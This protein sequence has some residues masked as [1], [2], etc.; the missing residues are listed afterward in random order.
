MFQSG[1]Y[2]PIAFPGWAPVT[3]FL[4]FY[5]VLEILLVAGAGEFFPIIQ[6]PI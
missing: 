3:N 1:G 5:N 2:S 4:L 6:A